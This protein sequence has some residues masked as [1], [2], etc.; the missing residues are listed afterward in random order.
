[1]KWSN[2]STNLSLKNVS[3][4]GCRNVGTLYETGRSVQVTREMDRYCLDI[5]GLSEVR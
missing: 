2:L 5:L 1:M 4:I 3:R